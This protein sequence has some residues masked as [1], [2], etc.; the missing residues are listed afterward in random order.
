MRYIYVYTKERYIKINIMILFSVIFLSLRRSACSMFRIPTIAL[1][2][3]SSLR[4]L[5]LAAITTPNAAY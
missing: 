2:L 1:S 4:A 5:S 3:A